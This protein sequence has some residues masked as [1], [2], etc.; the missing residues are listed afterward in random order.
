MRAEL[1]VIQPA[2]Y[3]VPLV[4]YHCPRC[5]VVSPWFG[6]YAAVIYWRINHAC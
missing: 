3:R 2:W 5:H 4:R 6:E 1:E